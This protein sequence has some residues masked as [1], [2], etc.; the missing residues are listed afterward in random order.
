[1]SLPLRSLTASLG[2]LTLGAHMAQAEMTPLG[3]NVYMHFSNYYS[4]LVVIG[5]NGVLV[6]DPAWTDRAKTMQAEIAGITDKPVTHVVLTHEHYDHVGGTEVFEDAQIVCHA[7]CQKFFDLDVLGGAPDTVNQSFEDELTIDLG[8]KQVELLHMGS[9]DGVATT[10]VSVPADKVVATADMYDADSLT[11]SMWLEDRNYLGMRKILNELASWD[12][13]HS[14]S[15]HSASTDVAALRDH[16]AFLNDLYD[17][18]KTELDA[19]MAEG[20]PQ[21]AFALLGGDLPGQI[22]LPA[23]KDWN[24]YDEHLSTHAWRMGMSIMHGG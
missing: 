2:A 21:A 15:G 10:I 13:N 11:D 19:A 14:V 9:G 3:D 22:D 17:A 20:G 12:L 1:M 8:G 4:S 5:D 18:V 16:A 6:V 23:Y 7:T 24:G